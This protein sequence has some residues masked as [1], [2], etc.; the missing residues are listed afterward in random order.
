MFVYRDVMGGIGMLISDNECIKLE[1]GIM[2]L[3]II[4]NGYSGKEGLQ[5]VV[6]YMLEFLKEFVV[7]KDEELIY[8]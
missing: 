8:F 6:D 4:I 3:L 5:E 1:V 2:Y 7:F